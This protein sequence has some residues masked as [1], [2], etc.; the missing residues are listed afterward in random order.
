VAG[1]DW[2]L[3]VNA[4]TRTPARFAAFR[5]I[6]R[7]M[8]ES[9]PLG[10]STVRVRCFGHT[11][12]TGWTT[13]PSAHGV[14]YL[15]ADHPRVDVMLSVHNACPRSLAGDGWSPFTDRHAL[16]GR[17][18]VRTRTIHVGNGLSGVLLRT[19]DDSGATRPELALAELVDDRFLYRVALE[20]ADDDEAEAHR[21]F[22]QV[23]ESIIPVPRPHRAEIFSARAAAEWAQWAD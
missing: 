7:R 17:A 3:L 2:A 21:A 12:P 4:G 8:A 16:H 5:A 23:V 6:A 13:I 14:H 10:L 9:V 20:Y 19:S 1:D 15:H 22:A 11:P 18:G